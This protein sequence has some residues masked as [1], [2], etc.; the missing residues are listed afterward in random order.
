VADFSSA[1]NGKRMPDLVAPGARVLGLR[2]PGSNL[3]VTA[4]EARR[5]DSLFRGSGTSQSAA[6]VS[7][8]AALL[9]QQRP[10]LTPPQVK[11]LLTST[12]RDLPEHKQISGDGLL[13]VAAAS[14][15]ATPSRTE[16]LKRMTGVGS[17]EEARG[18]LHVLSNGVPLDGER[19]I[20]GR[21]YD[22]AER[23]SAR[24]N[25][26][27]WS[28]GTWNGASW[29]GASW[30]GAS[31]SGASWSGASWSGASWSGA[32]WSGA[33]WSGASWSGASWSGA[34]WS[35]ASWSGASWSG[36]SWSGASWSGA[37][38]SG[39]SWSGASWSGAS[40]SG[41]TWYGNAW[42]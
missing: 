1:G 3:D 18:S 37:S 9:L 35:G 33:S 31:W 38:W 6:V 13:D 42:A 27:S 15:A 2:V 20:F 17:L 32:S 5:G 4:P 25:G 10:T 28:G 11:E 12:A 26:A 14:A 29:S 39:A 22:S 7:G 30:S 34:S 8:A 21:V 19:D 24:V 23:A 40:W 41:G 16:P 36:A